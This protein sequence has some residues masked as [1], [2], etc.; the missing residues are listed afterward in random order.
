MLAVVVLVPSLAFGWGCDG[1]R[2]VSM[3]AWA[4][5]SDAA[6]AGTTALLR[7]NPIDAAHRGCSPASRNVLADAST[8]ADAVRENEPDTASWHYM[9]V[10]RDA[11][12]DELGRLCPFGRCVVG[13]LR[14]QVEILRS[15]ASDAARARALR[16]VIHLVGDLHQPLHVTTNG[17]RGGNCVPIAYR[18]ES[19]HA[20]ADGERWEPNLHGIWDTELVRVVL[21]GETPAPV[22]AGLV[23]RWRAAIRAWKRGPIDPAAWAW[24]AHEAG[25]ETGYGR[26]PVV[27]PLASHARADSCRDDDVGRRMLRLG[28]RIEASYVDAARVVVERQLVR[29]GARLALVLNDVWR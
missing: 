14:R 8:W 27:P 21:D 19:P 16:F 12:R 17:D 20:F 3:I 5:L 11:A 26:L 18:R 4:E 23:R 2:V 6:R 7:A 28:E 29:A 24:E 9:N 25:V 13:A 1:H 10:P 22:A 15:N